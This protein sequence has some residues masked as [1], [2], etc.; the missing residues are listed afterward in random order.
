MTSSASLIKN[1]ATPS[2][3]SGKRFD[4]RDDNQ[5]VT[6]I[7]VWVADGNGAYKDRKL[8]KAIKL[9][10]AT[11]N[12][13][14]VGNTGDQAVERSVTIGEEEPFEMMNL[15]TGDR[16]DRI[17]FQTSNNSK[18]N[19]WGGPSSGAK[20]GSKKEQMLGDSAI[21]LGFHGQAN[22][23][24]GILSLGSYFTD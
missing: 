15:W 18:E 1:P 16:V 6:K 12:T 4:L 22:G 11:G 19:N 24:D 8:V 13:K 17:Q 9:E 7:T 20:G 14:Q 23:T 21:F 5:P 2:T 3:S 10:F